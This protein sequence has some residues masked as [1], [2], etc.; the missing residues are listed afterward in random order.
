[1][2][3]V[4][5]TIGL[6]LFIPTRAGSH[7]HPTQRRTLSAE[8]KPPYQQSTDLPEVIRKGQ[9][10]ATRRERKRE[11]I[12]NTSSSRRIRHQ[13][14]SQ[15]LMQL[16]NVT[17]QVARAKKQERRIA[18]SPNPTVKSCQHARRLDLSHDDLIRYH[19]HPSTLQPPRQ[20]EIHGLLQT[21]EHSP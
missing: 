15:S 18:V 12:K 11:R 13:I 6:V 2:Q 4:K 16:E 10:K 14:A 7:R 9:E 20:P 21:S 19:Q 8:H 1:M 17:M 3:Y 5:G